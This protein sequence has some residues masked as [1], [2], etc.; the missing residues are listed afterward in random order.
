LKILCLSRRTWSSWVRQMMASQSGTASS[1]PFTPRAAIARANACAVTSVQLA[2]RFWC[3]SFGASTAHPVHVSSLSGQADACI[4][5]VI[6]DDR[7]GCGHRVP[8]SRRFS[9]DR[10]WLL[11]PSCARRGVGPPSRSAYRDTSRTRRGCHVPHG[12]DPAGVGALCTPGRRC[13]PRLAPSHQPPPAVSQR[14]ALPPATHPISGGID[15]EASSRVRVYSP[16]RPS[17]ACDPDG[18]GALGRLL[19]ASHPAVTGN[20]RQSGDGS[21]N[22][23]PELRCCHRAQPSNQRAHSNRAT[24]CRTEEVEPVAHV[25]DLGLG[26]GR[27][28]PQWRQHGG[29]VFA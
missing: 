4:R 9:A 23:Y 5:P 14:P 22:T 17:L 10:H 18:S 11:G 27:P 2:L 1:G 24:S 29:D 28:Q 3:I 6:R 7:E 16:V 25:D 12:R 15:V 21:L 13:S 8:V 26:R 19:R 20:A